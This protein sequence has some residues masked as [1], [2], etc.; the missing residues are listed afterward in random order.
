MRIGIG[1]AAGL[2][3]LPCPEFA[4]VLF[5]LWVFWENL[6]N[7]TLRVYDDYQ[8]TKTQKALQGSLSANVEA[9]YV[10][11]LTMRSMAERQRRS[12]AKLARQRRIKAVYSGI[13]R[14][15]AW[16]RHLIES[17]ESIPMRAAAGEE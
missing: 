13:A 6:G 17:E 7:L 12:K 1:V 8:L 9:Y 10:H 5:F 16:V 11:M 15:S 4:V 14:A 3:L 2:M